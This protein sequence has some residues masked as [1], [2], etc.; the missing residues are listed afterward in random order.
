M[1][2]EPA[3]RA[4]IAERLRR[5]P[6]QAGAGGR[7]HA[8]A[9]AVAVIDAAFGAGL[10]GM[11][12]H[13]ERSTEAAVVLTL[14][15][16]KLRNHPGQFA[17]PGG[18]IDA[19]ETPEQTALREMREEVGLD[20]D[21]GSVLG[22]LDDFVTRSGFV[23]TPVVVWAGPDRELVPNAHEVASIFRIPAGE[24][25]REDSPVV[26]P[27]GEAGAP[28]LRLLLGDTWVGA[29]TA[30]ILYQFREVCLRDNLVRVAHYEQPGFAWR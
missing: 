1:R 25:L 21:P 3:L 5:F 19:G 4:R 26:E 11:P 24:L 10:P 27:V 9:V 6:V 15:S 23:M 12:S 22:R 30:A 28:L 7:S 14:R 17:L 29:P 2:C 8:S 20:L 13:A 18:R 16:H